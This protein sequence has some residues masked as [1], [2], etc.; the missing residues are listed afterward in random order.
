MEEDIQKVKFEEEFRVCPVCG[1]TDGFHTMLKK[2]EDK[3][4]WMFI[5]P[6]CHKVFDI[7]TTLD[8]F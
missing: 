1:Y 7:G 2:D 8:S 5:C 3:V 4:K 6:A